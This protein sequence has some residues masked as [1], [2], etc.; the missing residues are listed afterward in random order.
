MNPTTIYCIVFAFLLALVIYLQKKYCIVCNNCP[1]H[2]KPYSFSRS[3][4]VWWTFI[5]FSVFISIIIATGKI[6]T[7]DN[8]TLILLGIG[9]LT[10]V[11]ARLI[12][13]ND[14]ANFDAANAAAANQAPV[15]TPAA[16]PPV[17][18]AAPA[19]TA[20]QAA[21]ATP[22]AIPAPATTPAPAATP[23]LAQ[24]ITRHNFL[25]D[26]LSDKNSISIHRLQAFI[27][28]LVFGFW[29]IYS[30]FENIKGIGIASAQSQI[31]AVIPIITSN[32]LILLGVSAGLYTTLKTTENK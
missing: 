2:P 10:T 15:A 16:A 17:V 11:S 1:T 7:F 29:F 12:D 32:N 21:P 8:S 18:P 14:T 28:N 5:I 19:D 4:L 22:P 3:Q 9:S 6:P 24:Y 23:K 13:I 26:I 31:D 30:S 25:L 20:D 27:F